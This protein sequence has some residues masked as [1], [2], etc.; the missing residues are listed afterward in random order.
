M[1]LMMGH[2]Q[3]VFVVCFHHCNLMIIN[4]KTHTSMYN[5]T[6]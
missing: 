6:I 4:Y 1:D 2:L 3:A 5:V